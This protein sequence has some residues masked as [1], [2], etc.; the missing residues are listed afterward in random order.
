MVYIYYFRRCELLPY[1]DGE[2]EA[3]RPNWAFIERLRDEINAERTL[4]GNPVVRGEEAYYI[5]ELS[6]FFSLG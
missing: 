1:R 3:C 4:D 5:V 6:M 2:G